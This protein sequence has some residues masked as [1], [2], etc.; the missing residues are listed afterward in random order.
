VFEEYY[1]VVFPSN[2]SYMIVKVWSCACFEGVSL[3]LS[4]LKHFYMSVLKPVVFVSSE[5]VLLILFGTL[6]VNDVWCVS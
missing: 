5:E 6:L 2:C 3:V 4:V 1:D